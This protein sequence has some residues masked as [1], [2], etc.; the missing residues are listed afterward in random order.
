MIVCK[1]LDRTFETKEEL[2]KALKENKDQLI[3][4]KKA[5]ILKSCEKGT[6]VKTKSIDVSKFTNQAIKNEFK[7]DNYYYIAVNTTGIL[8]S[9]K[10]LH[11]KGI[12][13]K[14]AKEQNRKNYL[15]DTHVMSMNTTIARKEHVEMFVADIPFSSIGKSY[16]GNTEA[17][18]YKVPKDKII[19]PLAKEWL[20]SG[21]DIEA[22]VRM[23]YVNIKLALNSD[24][25]EDEAEKANYDNYLNQ[26][27]NKSDFDSIDYFWVVKEAK[28]QGES[29]LVLQGS[30]GATGQVQVNN[31]PSKDTQENKEAVDNTSE[32][33]KLYNNIKF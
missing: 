21:D 8:D 27:S 20:E 3:T 18:I 16:E 19:S 17:L 10:D 13:N 9:H 1:E 33:I 14:T 7:D 23:Q 31:E 29:S 2:F 28:N 15:V 12:W 22:S 24:S 25:I 6:S 11:V 26:I 5:Q 30:N 32:L 4:A